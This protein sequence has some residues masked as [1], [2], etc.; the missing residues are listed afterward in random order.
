MYMFVMGID[1]VSFYEQLNTTKTMTYGLE[2]KCVGVKPFNGI[3]PPPPLIIACP[4]TI[5]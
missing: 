3:P 1:F 5:Q 2:Q 4:T